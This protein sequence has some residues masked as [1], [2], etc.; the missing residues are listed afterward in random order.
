MNSSQAFA[1]F[2]EALECSESE[3]AVFVDF[4]CA[5]DNE[6]RREVYRLLDEEG[7]SNTTPITVARPTHTPIA[8]KVIRSIA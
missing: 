2:Q 3:Q 5:G 7:E 6:L 4:A 1:I 8:E